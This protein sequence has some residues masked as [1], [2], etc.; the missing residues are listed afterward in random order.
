MIKKLYLKNIALITCQELE[1]SSG[2]NVLSGETGAGKTVIISSINFVLGAKAD[3]TMIRYGEEFCEGEVIFDITKNNEVKQLLQEYDIDFSDDELIVRRKLY[4]DGKSQIRINGVQVTLQMLKS[5]TSLLC[6][7]YGQSE[8]YSLLKESNQLKILDLYASKDLLEPITQIKSVVDQIKS[9]KKS[10]EELGGDEKSRSDRID[11]LSYQINEIEKAEL[12]DGEE[13]ELIKKRKFFSNVEKIGEALQASYAMFSEDNG[14]V[15]LT[16]TSERKIDSVSSFSEDLS[17]LAERLSSVKAEVE[18]ISYTLNN[19]LENLDYNEQEKAF[20]DERLDLYHNLK[21]KYGNTYEE[22]MEYFS[23]SQIEL[24]NLKNF[25][26]L[27]SG[28]ENAISKGFIELDKLY[29]KVTKIRKEY[30]EKF[31][32]EISKELTTLGMK[33]AIFKVEV[34]ENGSLESLSVNGINSVIFYFTAN[35][36]E[37]LKTMSKVISGGEMSR[38]MLSLKLVSSSFEEPCTYIFDEIDAGISGLVSER[39][40]EKFS[41][42]SKDNQIIAISHLPQI[43]SYSDKSFLIE[44]TSDEVST[45]TIV[46]EL[47][48][49]EKEDEILRIIGA[50]ADEKSR[51]IAKDIIEKATKRKQEIRKV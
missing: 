37:P 34:L 2:I 43:V 5:V 48:N 28:Y 12:Y 47:S 49:I 45:H 31:S 16:S 22:I 33:D 1:F 38:F 32:Q 13:D 19:L 10:L 4:Q 14:V 50:K 21:R 30:G 23:K 42:L 46:K 7:V 35:K 24:E 40:A 18:D 39:V 51:Q 3:K 41:E 26:T 25:S 36:G 17:S 29:K 20:V 6:D 9:A 8:H 11:L 15:D 27:A 44:K